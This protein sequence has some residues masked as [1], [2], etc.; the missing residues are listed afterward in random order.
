MMKW[1]AALMMAA[2]LAGQLSAQTSSA[3]WEALFRQ[4]EA[5]HRSGDVWKARQFLLSALRVSTPVQSV[6]TRYALGGTEELMKRYTDAERNYHLGL[7]ALQREEGLP[8][9]LR[10]LWTARLNNGIGVIEVQR[11]NLDKAEAAFRIA[12]T[13][14]EPDPD[15]TVALDRASTLQNLGN[16]MFR[17][18]RGEEALATLYDA[19]KLYDMHGAQAQLPRSFALANAAIVASKLDRKEEADRLS[20]EA[21]DAF[22]K[23]AGER[24]PRRAA[25][26]RIRANIL[27]GIDRKKEARQMLRD[28]DGLTQDASADAFLDIS[29][30]GR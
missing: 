13:A 1:I 15:E 20:Q 29:A 30:Y 21:L 28:A 12:W 16:V 14:I 18:G 7:D 4:A 27:K 9:D 24:H 25:F 26:L 23:N 2:G 19:V 6:M 17:R 11:R 8:D 5:V 3:S 22:T 10:R